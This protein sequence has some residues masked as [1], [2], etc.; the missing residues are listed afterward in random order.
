MKNIYILALATFFALGAT[1]QSEAPFIDGELLVQVVDNNKVDQLTNDLREVQG[2]STQLEALELLSNHM[3]IWKFTFD[4]DAISTRDMRIAFDRHP[5]VSIVQYNHYVQLREV[6]NDTNYGNQWHHNDPQDNDIDTEEAWDITTGGTTAFGDEIV[7]CV[8]EGGNLN[9]EDLE[10]N[11]W[12]NDQEIPDNGIDD[13]G[14]GYVDDYDGWNVGSDD[15]SGVF[16]GGHGTQVMGMIGAKGDNDQGVAGANWDVKIMSVAGENIFN[17]ASVI[18]AYDYP[19]EMRKLYNNTGGAQG[20]FVVATN[21]SWGIDN[22][23]PNDIPLWCNFYDTLGTYG[24]LN[25]GATANN[26]VNIDVVGDI[27]TACASDYMISVTATN[28]SDVRTFSAYGATTIDLGAPGESVW[29]TQGSNAYGA[30][31]GTSFA[32]PLTA[33]AIALIYSTPCPSFMALVQ[34]DPHAGADYVRQV[35]FEGTDAVANLADECVTGGRLNVNNSINLIL[36][37]CSDS[38]CLTPF[39]VAMTQSGEDY[40][41]TWGET[42][43]MISFGV[44]YRETGADEW[45]EVMDLTDSSYT[46]SNLLWCTEYEVEVMATCEEGDSDWSNTLVFTTD[47]CCENPA[48]ESITVT[49]ISETGAT[50]SWESILAADFYNVTITPA[51]GGEALEFPAVNNS[52]LVS[53]LDTCTVYEVTI[54]TE[55]GEEL[56]DPT[57]AITFNTVGCGACADLDFCIPDGNTGEEWIENFEFNTLS[58]NSGANEGYADYTENPA[59]ST[60]VDPGATYPMTLT[61]GFEG[62]AYTEYFLVWLDMN[63]DGEFEDN[64][65]IYDPGAG[66]TE[67]ITTNVNVPAT[68]TPGSSRLRV[69]M[70]YVGGFG[71]PELPTPCEEVEYGEFEDYCIEVTDNIISVE[72]TGRVNWNLYPNPAT[73]VLN[74]TVPS[75]AYN[76]EVVELTGRILESTMIQGNAVVNT[77]DYASGIYIV[78]LIQDGQILGMEKVIIK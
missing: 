63:Q 62:F 48:I 77:S 13:D 65:I 11:K 24:I 3:H 26:N 54:A 51:G 57:D 60:T 71:D 14:N 70:K 32:S 73:D 31:S 53:D 44:R 46:L 59:L 7:V 23:D 69:A 64:E 38:E 29:T 66:T 40:T 21:A 28:S 2:V 47:G 17:E 52:L 22:G 30:T 41:I 27:P 18:E 76:L 33:G 55:C 12:F 16:N 68:A 39:S 19:L 35:L 4:A 20:A 8:I 25:C 56:L 42:A 6:P 74:I 58:N 45:T 5:L 37:S 67:E 43:A 1:A 49:G 10:A 75:G 50:I 61:P 36:N 34:G 9:H 72:E 78:R 15:D